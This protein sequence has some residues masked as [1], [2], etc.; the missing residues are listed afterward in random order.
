ME[1]LNKRNKL[2]PSRALTKARVSNSNQA[3]YNYKDDDTPLNIL[4]TSARAYYVLYI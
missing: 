1:N 2:M 4:T 3:A